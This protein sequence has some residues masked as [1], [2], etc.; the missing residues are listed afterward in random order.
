MLAIDI[1]PHPPLNER[2]YLKKKRTRACP[3]PAALLHEPGR[4]DR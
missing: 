2:R 3:R 4:D 1:C